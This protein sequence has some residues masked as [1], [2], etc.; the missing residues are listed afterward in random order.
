MKYKHRILVF[1]TV[2]LNKLVAS[3]RVVD[4]SRRHNPHCDEWM[5]SVYLVKWFNV[6]SLEFRT[7]S[8]CNNFFGQIRT[9]LNAILTCITL[10]LWCVIDLCRLVYGYSTN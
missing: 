2:S 1:F 5:Q 6:L 9:S 4:D 7:Y 10:T 8:K 3:N